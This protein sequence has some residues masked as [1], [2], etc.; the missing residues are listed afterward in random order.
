[1]LAILFLDIRGF[2]ALSEARL[3]YDTVFLL[4]RFFAE[5]GEAINKPGG[6]IDKYLGDGIAGAVRRKPAGGGGL[7]LGACRRDGDRCRSGPAQS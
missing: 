5:V 3:P 6:W 2:T 7:P 4:N 1:V